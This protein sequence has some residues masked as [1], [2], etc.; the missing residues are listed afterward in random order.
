M[1]NSN[2]ESVTIGEIVRAKGNQRGESETESETTQALWKSC[3]RKVSL[4]KWGTEMRKAWQDKQVP[5]CERI[6]TSC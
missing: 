6:C 4:G 3:G 1:N 2:T 5:E